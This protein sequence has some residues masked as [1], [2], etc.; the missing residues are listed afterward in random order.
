MLR[1]ILAGLIL[2]A[3][4]GIA[5]QFV[6]TVPPNALTHA[7]MH[8]MKR[9]IVRFASANDVLPKTVDQL[10]HM[11]GYDNGVLDG[12]GHRI[13]LQIDGGKVTMTSY[14]RDGIPGGTGEDVD[15]IAVFSV[16]TETG[17]WADELCEW[18]VDPY[19]R[20]TCRGGRDFCFQGYIGPPA[21]PPS[22]LRC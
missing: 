13:L 11:N 7:R 20:C 5:L 16:K 4:C 2:V 18:E 6:D 10:P 3:V 21:G 15:M 9:R 22:E 14:G 8:V 1:F 12:W 17:V 19:G